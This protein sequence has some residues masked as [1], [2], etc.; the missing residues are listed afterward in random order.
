MRK[1]I[2]AV[3]A[4]AWFFGHFATPA[5]AAPVALTIGVLPTAQQVPQSLSDPCIICGT[6]QSHN[7][8]NFGYNNFVSNGNLSAYNTFSTNIIGGGPL[9]GDLEANALPY[10]GALLE[11]FLNGG[12]TDPLFHFGIVVDINTA[13]GGE[14]LQ[15]FQLLDLSKP[16]GQQDIFD[17][18][19]LLPFAMPD[20]QNGNGKGDYLISGFDLSLGC[21][22]S[23]SFVLA[24]CVIQPGDNLL[25]HASW[26]GASDG[27]E[28]F[29][30]VAVP[31]A[32]V[33]DTPEPLAITILGVGLLG[34]GAIKSR[35][36]FTFPM[37]NIGE[38]ERG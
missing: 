14:T 22:D 33:V 2:C 30:M 6:N 25:F 20:T 29:Y 31:T 3:V 21:R 12:G 34:L 8:S 7:P 1:L 38:A 23:G 37:Q 17:L 35:W 27:A 9:L 28:S 5:R 11:N 4:G 26:T 13:S 19:P 18:S 16:L 15:S 32:V 36:R 24:D 10:S